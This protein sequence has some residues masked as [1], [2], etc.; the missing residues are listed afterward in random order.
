[1]TRVLAA[2]GGV[3]AVTLSIAGL[4]IFDSISSISVAFATVVAVCLMLWWWHWQRIPTLF[5]RKIVLLALL[6]V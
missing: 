4:L 1:M 2:I 3:T 5:N 6:A